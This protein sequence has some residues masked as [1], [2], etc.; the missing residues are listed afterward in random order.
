VEWLKNF[1]KISGYKVVSKC[2]NCGARVVGK[3]ESYY[4]DSCLAKLRTYRA[5]EEDR[6]EA[7][8]KAAKKKADGSGKKVRR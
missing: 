6:V 1:Q 2:R 5:A 8:K 4:C 3:S 7:E